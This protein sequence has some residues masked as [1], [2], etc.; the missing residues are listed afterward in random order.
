[1]V[2]AAVFGLPDAVYGERVV[3]VIV[4]SSD[5]RVE[6][7]REWMALHIPPYKVESKDYG[8]MVLGFAGNTQTVI[9]TSQNICHP[10]TTKSYLTCV[11]CPTLCDYC[12]LIAQVPSVI[13][14]LDS[15]PKNAMGKV[16][17]QRASCVYHEEC[18]YNVHVD[19]HIR[20]AII[21]HQTTIL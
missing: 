5:V 17:S 14:V 2:E 15:I 19:V 12:A 13:H 11:V 7:V 4:G 20:C 1:M 3:A 6:E 9:A 16:R 10:R 18:K 21:I 8:R